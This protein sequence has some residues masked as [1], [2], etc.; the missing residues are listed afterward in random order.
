M[1]LK[2]LVDKPDDTSSAVPLSVSLTFLE[3]GKDY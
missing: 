1:E 2:S 3:F